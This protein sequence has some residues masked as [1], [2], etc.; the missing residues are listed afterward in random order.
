[1]SSS[2]KEVRGWLRKMTDGD[3]TKVAVHLEG[4]APSYHCSTCQKPFYFDAKKER[5]LCVECSYEFDVINGLRI[6]QYHIDRLVQVSA[7]MIETLPDNELQRLLVLSPE[8]VSMILDPD[9]EGALEALVEEVE[10]ERSAV[11]PRRSFWSRLCFWRKTP[12]YL[13]Y[14]DDV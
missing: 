13:P 2:D 11:A 3:V 4:P 6:F 14:E 8:T 9:Q 10:G 1:M 5:F 7:A 12:R